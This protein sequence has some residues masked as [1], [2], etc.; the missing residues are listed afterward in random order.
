[1]L[2]T[3]FYFLKLILGYQPRIPL[4]DVFGWIPSDINIIFPSF[5]IIGS[6]WRC[7]LRP[8]F[9]P[10]R[11]ENSWT[12]T[13]DVAPPKIIKSTT[14][15]LEPLAIF[16]SNSKV[17]RKPTRQKYKQVDYNPSLAETFIT[18]RLTGYTNTQGNI[19][20]NV[21]YTHTY[22]FHLIKMKSLSERI[23]NAIF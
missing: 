12:N 22:Y 1:M 15:F 18:K 3:P 9:M 6:L 10:Q 11:Q 14:A 19:F 20:G 21:Y 2:L 5:D 17:V 16:K 23:F 8:I 7:I 4:N 13:K